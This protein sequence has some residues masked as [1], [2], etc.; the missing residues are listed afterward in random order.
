[1]ASRIATEQSL[2]HRRRNQLERQLEHGEALF[3]W[4]KLAMAT[5]PNDRAYAVNYNWMLDADVGGHLLS[6]PV[7]HSIKRPLESRLWFRYPNQ[8][9]TSA[10]AL[11]GSGARP[12]LMGRVLPGGA[13]QVIQVAYN[14]QGKV[15]SYTDPLGRQT[16]YSYATNGLDLLEVRQA[17]SGGTDLLHSF[18]SYNTMHLPATATDGALQDTDFTYNALGQPLT[19][20]NARN[21]TTTFDYGSTA[22]TLTSVTGPVSGATTSF[23]YDA[24]GRV[25]TVTTSDGYLVEFAY[26]ALNRVISKTYPDATTETFAYDRLDLKEVKDRL[27]RIT[28]HFY[29]GYGRLIATR[30]PAGRTVSYVWCSC[31]VLEALMD[32]KGQRTTWERDAQGRVTRE[33]RADGTTDTVYSYDGAGRLATVTDPLDQVTTYT[34]NVDGSLASTGFTDDVIATPDISHTYDAYYP[35]QATM[36]DGNGTTTYSYV[37]AGTNGAGAVASVDGPF[38]NDT[39][40]YTYD[41]L[42]RVATRMLNSTG[43]ELTYDVLGRLS[44]LEFPIG[45][46]DYTYVAQTGRRST[47]TYPNGQTTT[48]S[49]LD[50]EHDFRLQ[51]IHHKNPSAATLSKFDYTYDTVGNI[52]TWRQERAGSAAKIY[53]FT[54]DLADQLTSAVLTDTS[55]PATILERQAWAYDEAGNRTVDQTDDAVFATSHDAMNRLQ[56]RAPGGP[57]VFAGSLNEAGTVTIDGTPAQVDASNNFTGTATLSGATTTVTVKAKDASGNET[58]QQYEVDASGNTTSYT[59]DANGNLTA[60]GTKTYSW[61]ALN[62]LVEVKEGTTTIAT[63]EYDGAGRRTEKVAAGL[64]HTYVYDAG[65]TSEERITG[66]SSD[67]IRYYYG[68]KVDEPLARK[69][70]ADVVTYY[71]TDQ[72]GSIVQESNSGGAVTMERDYDLWGNPVEGAGVS[73][74]AFVGRDWDSETQLYYY[75]A[76]YYSSENA[77]FLNEDPLGFESGDQNFYSYVGNGPSGRVDPTGTSYYSNVAFLFNFVTG[78][79]ADSREYGPQNWETVEMADSPGV[80][81]LRSTFQTG[82]CTDI[83]TWGY[84]SGEAWYDTLVSPYNSDWS[85]TAAQVGGFDRASVKNNGD[86]TA[87]YTIPNKAGRHSFVYH[88][89]SDKTSSSG[90]MRT[91]TQTFKW[92]EPT[93]CKK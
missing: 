23:T 81:K 12:S 74:F 47:V 22:K 62:Q 1:V 14:T 73:G 20:T 7:P 40:N 21:E 31:G 36:M 76:R 54:H 48:Y 68:A 71:L 69:N 39:I 37:A 90:P 60:D 63:F 16:T 57:I 77:R 17:V 45:T 15:T 78:R 27:G 35:R 67:T 44:Q 19:V 92:T 13:S 32:A 11:G 61:N 46:F 64:T 75:R 18:S 30:D 79:G 89:M 80:R 9:S 59:Y 66:S 4:D 85:S 42:G 24:V 33:I 55:T 5:H 53:T 26:D 52:L 10:H 41:E 86:G 83:P 87:T 91:I 84:G 82:G 49:Y 58:T 51:T 29:D 56:S 93:G 28:R 43:T 38:S 88:A 3:Y 2:D 65:N 8:I 25:E 72:L 70:S 50:D 6:R 34:Y